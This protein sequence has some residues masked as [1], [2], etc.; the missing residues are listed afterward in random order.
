MHIGAKL[1]LISGSKPLKITHR[2]FY[3]GL[4]GGTSRTF[5]G[6]NIGDAS[7]DRMV[8][9]FCQGWHSPGAGLSSLTIGGV[10]GTVQAI[11]YI[12]WVP[13]AAGSAIIPTGTTADITVNFDQ[14]LSGIMAHICTIEGITSNTPVLN[15]TDTT[16]PLS[17]TGT[18]EPSAIIGFA[19]NYN[20]DSAWSW[21]GT[22]GL[23]ANAQGYI[24][25]NLS[26]SVASLVNTE[27]GSKTIIATPPGAFNRGSLIIL[28]FK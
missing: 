12:P 13:T 16:D 7:P 26:S 5:Y 1:G 4:G 8:V 25:S 24:S 20:A 10:S 6:V 9:V 27:S 3:G 14:S 28:G 11:N 15:L 17:V 22:L 21:G 23:I 2:G 19:S 18:V